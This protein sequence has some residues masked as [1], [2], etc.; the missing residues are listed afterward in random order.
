LFLTGLGRVETAEYSL[1]QE[2]KVFSLSILSL[3]W[4][5]DVLCVFSFKCISDF[6]NGGCKKEIDGF[7]QERG[8]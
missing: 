6:E 1:K 2:Y 3:I 7:E 8:K 5:T 4:R